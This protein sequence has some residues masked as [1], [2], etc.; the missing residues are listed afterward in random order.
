[1]P[2]LHLPPSSKAQRPSDGA[3]VRSFPLYRA[4][5]TN[6]YHDVAAIF[7]GAAFIQSKDP[8]IPSLSRRSIGC[9]IY[10]LGRLSRPLAVVR[11]GSCTLNP[12]RT[13]SLG[14]S[15]APLLRYLPAIVLLTYVSLLLGLDPSLPIIHLASSL[16][17][18]R[19]LCHCH[20]PNIS[21]APHDRL[22]RNSLPAAF[23]LNSLASSSSHAYYLAQYTVPASIVRLVPKSAAAPSTLRRFHPVLSFRVVTLHVTVSW[24]LPYSQTFSRLPSPSV[25][26]RPLLVQPMPTF[27]IPRYLIPVFPCSRVLVHTG[28]V[29]YH[30][31]INGVSYR[32]LA[33]CTRT[34]DR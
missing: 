13:Y 17:P 21:F 7:F 22:D 18:V 1:M 3:G 31:H 29:D 14:P 34:V 19:L 4:R 10:Q 8:V 16:C 25:R 28:R 9:V 26:S 23:P 6:K 30:V 32:T 15:N 5:N 11:F 12:H 33:V 24:F 20:L 2:H 27:P